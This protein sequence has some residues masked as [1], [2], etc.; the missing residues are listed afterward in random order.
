MSTEG[1][2]GALLAARLTF[3]Q[4]SFAGV[5]LSSSAFQLWL[6]GLFLGLQPAELGLQLSPVLGYVLFSGAQ[7]VVTDPWLLVPLTGLRVPG[8]SPG[9][10]GC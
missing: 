8:T 9:F 5:D 1:V 3:G 2:V 6:G 10:P 7:P 4:K